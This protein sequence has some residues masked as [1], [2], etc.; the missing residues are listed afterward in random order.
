[1]EEKR[2]EKQIHKDGIRRTILTNTGNDTAK[3]FTKEELQKK[4]FL[5]GEEGECEFLDKLQKRG[6]SYDESEN[7]EH[8][9]SSHKGVVGQSSHDIV[10][11]LPE[12]FYLEELI[13]SPTNQPFSSPP[14]PFSS[15]PIEAQWFAKKTEPKIMGRSLAVPSERTNCLDNKEN[16]EKHYSSK[17]EKNNFVDGESKQKFRD[18]VDSQASTT[19]EK[20]LSKANNLRRSG[21]KEQA[22]GLLMDLLDRKG[23][24]LNKD[25]LSKVHER[26]IVIT[27]ELGWLATQD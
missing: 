3:Y 5:L 8:S 6:F 1:V 22:V 10:Y 13:Q 18:S 24:T 21:E 12:N 17:T 25:D 15:P 4:L 7:P 27:N 26:M 20:T 2:Y 14:Q 23:G 19:V 11:S 9:Y 16:K